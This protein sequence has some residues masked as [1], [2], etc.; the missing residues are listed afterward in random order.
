[1]VVEGTVPSGACVR[2]HIVHLDVLGIAHKRAQFRTVM[3]DVGA[4]PPVDLAAIAGDL[5]TY[6]VRRRP[7]WASLN[8]MAVRAGFE[9]ATTAIPWTQK[10]FGVRQKLDAIFLAPPGLGRR[11]WA[12]PVQASD[13]LPIFVET[14]M[15]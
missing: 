10:A 11:A 8:A 15:R 1:M 5:N 3:D 2:V 12:E 9:D 13:H 6:G 4:R 14:E 7:G